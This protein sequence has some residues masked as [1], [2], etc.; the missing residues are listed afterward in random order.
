[1][2]ATK[3][4][5]EMEKQRGKKNSSDLDWKWLKNIHENLIV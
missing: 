2:P 1:M 4:I 5:Y 3:N